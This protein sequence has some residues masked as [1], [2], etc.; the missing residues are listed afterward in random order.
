MRTET[1]M[2]AK[3][4]HP[5]MTNEELEAQAIRE[6]EQLGRSMGNKKRGRKMQAEGGHE[7]RN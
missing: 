3:P 5:M 4:V 7:N 1:K 6:L 2:Q